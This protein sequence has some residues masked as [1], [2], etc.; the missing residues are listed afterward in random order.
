MCLDDMSPVEKGH[1]P[2]GFDPYFVAGVFREDGQG[3]DV[4]AEFACFS[5][6][7]WGCKILLCRTRGEK[8]LDTSPKIAAYP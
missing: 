1:L 5:E 6:F 8:Y 7:A 4:Q 2:V 3:R